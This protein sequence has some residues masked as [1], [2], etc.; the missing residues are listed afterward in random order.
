MAHG[1]GGS[2]ASRIFPDEGS[3]LCLLHWQADSL[4]LRPQGSPGILNFD[5]N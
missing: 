3:N 1:R 4:P 5:L 2:E